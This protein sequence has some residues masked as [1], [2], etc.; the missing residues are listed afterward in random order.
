MTTTVQVLSTGSEKGS[1]IY[2]ATEGL[3]ILID[4]GPSKTKI[5]KLLLAQNYDPTKIEAIFISHEH[6]DHVDGIGFADKFKI[7]IY[8]SEGTLK[9]ISRLDSGKVMKANGGIGFHAF[10][11]HHMIISAFNISHDAA[12]PFGYVIRTED[13]KVSVLMDTGCVNDG[14][15]A[16]M[17]H[18][19]VYVF[20]CNHDVDM[21]T[22]GSYGDYLKSRILSDIGH[23]SNDAAAE[24]LAKLIQGRGEQIYLTHMSKNNNTAALAERTVKLA[25]HSKGYIKGK[26]YKLEVI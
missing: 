11:P 10:S 25:L 26:H 13:K 18:S 5:E 3:S 16:A 22:N 17:A 4:V 1:C 15:L 6:G 19:D 20:E 24:A 9:S 7:P 21:L 12:E 2:V 8:A 14:M 23:M